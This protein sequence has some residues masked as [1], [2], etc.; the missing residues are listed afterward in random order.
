ML[1]QLQFVSK[2]TMKIIILMIITIIGICKN[3]QGQATIP[4]SRTA[5][6]TTPT[7]W[8]DGQGF[9]PTY[10]SD[11]CGGTGSSSGRL[12]NTGEYFI[13]NYERN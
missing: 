6:G 5:W 2:S 12:D 9:S 4:V 7:G 10:A 1:T 8:T 3:A 13:V 11:I